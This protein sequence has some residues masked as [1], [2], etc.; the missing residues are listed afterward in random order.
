MTG[1]EDDAYAILTKLA[2]DNGVDMPARQ[3]KKP[4]VSTTVE[5]VSVLDLFRGNVI[6]RRTVTLFIVWFSNSMLYYALT[7]SAGELGGNRY[8]NIGLA[9]LVE[10]P[11]YIA[12]YLFLD[13]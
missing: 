12:G 6:F 9:G 2:S 5:P 10:I 4:S 11:S 3:L 1:R 13:R 8:I 7:M